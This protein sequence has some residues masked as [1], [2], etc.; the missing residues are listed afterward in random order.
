MTRQSHD[1]PL[2][3]VDFEAAYRGE[4]LVDGMPDIP[5][6]PWDIGEAQPS[7]VE[8]E[9]TGGFSGEVLDVGCG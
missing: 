3:D 2:A 7:L 6:T 8:L 4:S 9:A 1:S 5:S